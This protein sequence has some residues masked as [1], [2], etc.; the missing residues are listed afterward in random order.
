MTMRDLSKRVEATPRRLGGW[1]KLLVRW[2]VSGGG[3]AAATGFAEASIR[4][5][6]VLL[7]H[8]LIHVP[9][10]LQAESAISQK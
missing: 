9:V 1:L 4:Q 3:G 6:P 10:R 5:T 7:I 8:S 2:F